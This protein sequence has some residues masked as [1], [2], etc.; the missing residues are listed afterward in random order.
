MR[1]RRM[2]LQRY[3]NTFK[4]VMEERRERFAGLMFEKA[5]LDRE[6]LRDWKASGGYVEG[7]REGRRVALMA[8]LGADEKRHD[9]PTL[10]H[11]VWKIKKSGDRLQ[12]NVARLDRTGRHDKTFDN[13][14]EQSL[15]L[16]RECANEEESLLQVFEKEYAALKNENDHAYA[17]LVS[18]EAEIIS[19]IHAIEKHMNAMAKELTAK[20][21][22][23]TQQDTR[24]Q[25]YTLAVCAATAACA[26][27]VYVVGI[28]EPHISPIVSLLALP[29]G[30]LSSAGV[31]WVTASQEETMNN[32]KRL[33][34]D[35]AS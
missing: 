31:R 28:A 23:L 18:E 35:G 25:G 3:A 24:M 11:I 13:Y 21:L 34:A 32:L 7:Y 6:L 17:D 12:T 22:A 15:A 30:V 4:R 5:K 27:S 10:R 16:E 26:F 29:I 1:K 8:L 9:D 14:M 20:M 19:L 2:D 33:L